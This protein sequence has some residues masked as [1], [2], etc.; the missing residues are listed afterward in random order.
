MQRPSIRSALPLQRYQYG[1]FQVVLLGQ[2]ET[3]D[4][5]QYQYLMAFVAEGQTQP[6]LYIS[7]EKSRRSEAEQ[8]SHRL[9]ALMEG[10]DEVLEVGNQWRHV[11]PFVQAAL[12]IGAQ[13]LSL[14]DETPLKL[15]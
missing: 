7:A 15:S 10:F 9:R 6:T 1:N 5:T 14:T 13:L 12:K 2:I 11:E 8:G 4:P 3:S